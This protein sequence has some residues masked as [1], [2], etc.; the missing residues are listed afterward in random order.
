M[1][2][3]ENSNIKPKCKLLGEDG[4]VFNLIGIA[5]KTLDKAGQR[6]N[7]DILREQLFNCDTYEDALLLIGKYVEIY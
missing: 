3:N 4:N 5:A 2:Q 6:E 1:N 7:A